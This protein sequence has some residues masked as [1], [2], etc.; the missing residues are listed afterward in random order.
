MAVVTWNGSSS[1]LYSTAA[2]WDTGSVPGDGDDVVI[3]DTSSIN[4]CNVRSNDSCNSLTVSTNGEIG[5]DNGSKLA[6]LGEADGTGATTNGFGVKIDGVITDNTTTSIDFDI[7]TQAATNIDLQ[8]TSGKVRNVVINHASCVATLDALLDI[9][10]NLTITA[11]ELNTNS[12]SNNA[13]TVA[14]DV[15]IS[16]TL[17]CNASAVS[18]GSLKCQGSSTL[19]A[20]SG[21]TTIT[22]ENSSGQA[23]VMNNTMTFNNNDGTFLITTPAATN[24]YFKSDNALHHLTINHSSADIVLAGNPD[25]LKCE[26]DLTITAGILRST[27]SGATLEV[28]GD[29]SV[30]GTLNWSGTSGGAVELGSLTINSGGTYSATSGT[31]TITSETSGGVAVSVASG[32]TFTHN[33][34]TV[35]IQTP[36][37]TFTS[38]VTFNYNNL[39]IN[40]SSAAVKFTGSSGSTMTIEGDL[41]ITQ[42]SFENNISDANLTVNGDVS[43]TGTLTGNSGAMTFG[44]LTIN[45]GGTY[46]ATSGTTTITKTSA[47]AGHSGQP[48]AIEVKSGGTFTNNDGT[49]L[50]SSSLDQDL[51]FDGTG[52]MHHL[53]INKSDNDVIHSSNLTI[54]G[55]LSITL[56]T[57]HT[58]RPNTGSRTLTVT[59]NAT[60]VEGK[61][62]DVT[63]YTGAMSFGSLSIEDGGT[64]IATSDTTTVTNGLVLASSGTLTQHA[65]GL[66]TC[67]T[68]TNI[69][70]S[71]TTV[72]NWTLTGDCE[73]DA[74][75]VSSGDTF[76]LNG[77]RAEFSGTLHL[78]GTCDFANAFV[79][80][81][82]SGILDDDGTDQNANSL[83]LVQQGTSTTT[84]DPPSGIGTYFYNQPSVT[85]T[86][87]KLA[88][89][90][91]FGAGTQTITGNPTGGDLTIATGA[92]VDA[93]DET[94]T[95]AGD[96]TTS[97]GLIGKSALDMDGSSTT[98]K[99]SDASD[100]DGLT[101]ATW[102]GWFKLDDISADRNFMGQSSS[103]S[104][105]IFEN[106]TNKTRFSLHDG[107]SFTDLEGN[108]TITVDN[109]WHHIAFVMDGSNNKMYT[110]IDGKLDAEGA[111]TG[112]LNGS[113]ADIYL[114]GYRSGNEKHFAGLYD[115][116]SIWNVALTP[117]QI[118]AKMFSNFASLDSNT[119]CVGFWQ[120]DE[121][122]GTSVASSVGSHTGTIANGTW[123]GAGTFS[124][125]TSTLVM[126]KSG[127]QTFTYNTGGEDVNNLTVNDGSTTNLKCLQDT[128]GVLDIFGNLVVNEKLGVTVNEQIKMK[129][130]DKT[131]TIGSDVKTSAVAD[132]F[133]IQL[134]HTSG[135]INIPELTT[136]RIT[137]RASSAT[138]TATGDLTV[139]T[140]LTCN[141]GSSFNANGNTINV[142]EFVA[143]TNTTLTFS[144]STLNFKVTDS[145]DTWTMN[146]GANFITGNT[147]VSGFSSTVHT[148]CFINQN[149]EV[150]GDVS[151]LKLYSNSDL[152]VV[153]S[154][155]NCSF[156]DTA[157]AIRQFFHTLDTQQL[158]DADEAG[159][160]DL[161]LTK[162]ALD[163]ALELMTK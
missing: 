84:A 78:L 114:G 105:Q 100:F 133:S 112:T 11:G 142:K 69:Q 89:V 30:T 25:D 99:V 93:N 102:M 118:R 35:E 136:K 50:L 39:I 75:T 159:D 44:S 2:N 61:L 41:T 77:Q 117:T 123:A 5:S 42:G 132:L 134:D 9:S 14:G 95:V 49:V 83:T 38:A 107:S 37:A 144:N 151:N 58:F 28:D 62:G 86:M 20:T 15:D 63:N 4:A 19:N 97:G 152:T 155:T 43:V 153:G 59:G 129:T 71:L 162:P 135:N 70:Q 72:G 76:D 16:G 90:H 48:S 10:G 146:N 54:E 126:A 27:T 56:A 125:G 73:F 45:S 21:T 85:Q 40:H 60:I 163:N 12:G 122:T 22:S 91:I 98:V 55:D 7:R 94:I 154:V 131:I 52:N 51:E 57:A 110:Y 124:Y 109:K 96:F 161:R 143:G 121:G 88:N 82:G 141:T 145:G 87:G 156:D 53:T 127:T 74:V 157:S 67:G 128:G 147:T 47:T 81:T 150:V 120:F 79:Y 1:T 36:A 138:T 23:I 137:C 139:T 92:T 148:P 64:Y 46:S 158:L 32:A 13:L 68:G 113:G 65:S 130:G 29:A 111:W 119:G 101:N 160:D 66:I 3:P 104:L 115:S 106:S 6:I 8:A 26:G 33:S 18:F 80:M 17:T 34:G 108:T 31:T 149:H 140:L 116:A 103:F 24:I